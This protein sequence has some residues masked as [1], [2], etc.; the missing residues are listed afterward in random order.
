MLPR[1]LLLFILVPLVEVA[2]LVVVD[3]AI[4]LPATIA[5]IF[6]TGVLGAALTRREGL[7]TLATYR[8]AVAAGRLPSRELIEGVLILL[9]GAV[10]LTPG[11][12]TDAVGFSLLVPRIRRWVASAVGERATQHVRSRAERFR[13]SLWESAGATQPP[14]GD[15]IDVDFD[16]VHAAR[17]ENSKPTTAAPDA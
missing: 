12:L 4:G 11:L 15:V 2:L 9:A 14:Q 13:Q 6:L 8:E 16:R 17:L 5:T 10:L 7:R 1:L 3:R